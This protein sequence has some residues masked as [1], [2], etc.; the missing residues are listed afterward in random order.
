MRR[1]M[2]AIT[3]GLILILTGCS[4]SADQPTTTTTLTSTPPIAKPAVNVDQLKSD[5]V[6]PKYDDLARYPDQYRGRHLVF[7]G[8]VVQVVDNVLRVNITDKGYDIWTD[9]IWVNLHT[10]DKI[11]ENDIIKVWGIGQGEIKYTTVMKAELTI[12]QVDVYATELIT[13]AGDR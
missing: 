3:I 2:V 9:T 7:T 11:L 12:P 10:T 4:G 8:E 5:A 6:T 1:L 13:K